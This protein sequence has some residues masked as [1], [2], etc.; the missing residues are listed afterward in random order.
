M[1]SAS[2]HIPVLVEA[3]LAALAPRD[4]AVYVDA[5]FGAG[6]YSE[7][8][9]GAARCRVFGIDRDPDAN[10]DCHCYT[11]CHADSH[12]RQA[13]HQSRLVVIRKQS[14]SR[15]YQQAQVSNDQERRHQRRPI[16]RRPDGD[17]VTFDVR[18][19]ISMQE[20]AR[21]RQK[22]QSV[23]DLQAIRRHAADWQPDDF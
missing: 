6:G 4:D 22:L 12:C 21:A 5:T 9:L 15:H 1:I 7:A 11:D 16:V 17:G 14:E 23:G 8:L 3:V 19:K 20:D 18:R 10:S 13:V 2:A